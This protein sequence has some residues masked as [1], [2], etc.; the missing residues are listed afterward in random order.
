M[1]GI[2]IPFRTEICKAELLDGGAGFHGMMC[3]LARTS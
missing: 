3:L 2:C 1:P